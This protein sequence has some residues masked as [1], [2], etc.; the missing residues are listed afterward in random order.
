[1]QLRKLTGLCEQDNC[2]GVYEADDGSIVVLGIFVD[3]EQLGAMN[4]ASSQSA[5]AISKELLLA[6]ARQLAAD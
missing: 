5:V 2:P 6:A 1:M 3:K 4:M